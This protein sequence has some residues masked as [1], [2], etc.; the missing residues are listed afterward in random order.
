MP[1]ISSSYGK[2][3]CTFETFFRTMYRRNF[4]FWFSFCLA[5]IKLRFLSHT[6]HSFQIRSLIEFSF[7]LFFCIFYVLNR[8]TLHSFYWL[9]YIQLWNYKLLVPIILYKLGWFSIF[10]CLFSGVVEWFKWLVLDLFYYLGAYFY[11]M[12]VH[13][14][15]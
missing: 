10:C 8:Y 7:G 6:I 15:I 12:W 11:A 4:F 5:P 2:I 14:I 1:T 9:S 3:L 13:T